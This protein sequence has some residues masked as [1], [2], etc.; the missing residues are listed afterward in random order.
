[1]IKK[2][3]TAEGLSGRNQMDWLYAVIAV[4]GNMRKRR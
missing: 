4:T 3:M 1:M 2:H